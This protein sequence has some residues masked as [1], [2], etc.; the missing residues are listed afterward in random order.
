MSPNKRRGSNAESLDSS[1]ATIPV[2]RQRVSVACDTC[3][4]AREKCD[5]RR[6]HCGPCTNRN[7][8]CSYN[9]TSKKRGVQPG[10]L[11]TIELSLAWLFE[12][13]PECEASLYRLLTENDEARI[14]GS[15]NKAGRRLY[16]RWSKSR[17]REEIVRLIADDKSR[18]GASP[19]SEGGSDTDLETFPELPRP[20]VE[21]SPRYDTLGA[22][23]PRTSGNLVLPPNWRRLLEIYFTCTHCWFP[24][25][26]RD[27]M[28]STAR[29]YPA[30]GF[31]TSIIGSLPGPN[32]LLWACLAIG[33][34]QDAA[35]PRP[36]DY[37]HLSPAKIFTIARRLI[38]SEDGTFETSHIC[39]LLLH[40][41]VLLGQGKQMAA[42]LLVG[43]ACRLALNES[44]DVIGEV[45]KQATSLVF[46]ACFMLDTLI[47]VCL[48]QTGHITTAMHNQRST[49]ISSNPAA[50][51]IDEMPEPWSP[52]SGLGPPTSTTISEPSAQPI[53]QPLLTFHQLIKICEILSTDTRSKRDPSAEGTKV[54]VEDLARCLDS[55]F[56]FCN[57]LIYGGS[58]P[59]IPSAYLLQAVF[60]TAT[61]ELIPEPRPSLFS[62]LVETIQ[63]CLDTLGACAAPPLIVT[64][65]GAVQRH[66]HMGRMHETD[67]DKWRL[68]IDALT[69]V[70][71]QGSRTQEI[72]PVPCNNPS[73]D[74]VL[75]DISIGPLITQTFSA[76]A[77][78][79]ETSD[80]LGLTNARTTTLAH[81]GHTETPPQPLLPLR[82]HSN[83]KAHETSFITTPRST[84]SIP[85]EHSP[86]VEGQNPALNL[87]SSASQVQGLDYDAILDELGSVDC[88][89]GVEV[90]PQF[91][92]NL[93]FA[94][95]CD[96]GEM[97]YGNYGL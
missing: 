54:T 75:N 4:T 58:T 95:G 45:P 57:S 67:K 63:S 20:P 47:S 90:D 66:G 62:N 50:A 5:G 59:T 37:G 79:G 8:A 7:R 43:N 74:D 48:G 84:G 9:S 89:D 61:I 42:W 15:K 92:A 35:S 96:L 73:Q 26:D 81:I 10:Y 80:E 93:G 6:P 87:Y 1:V 21:P 88:T 36:S 40:S 19:S 31:D 18:R 44:S 51:N 24:I 82:Q 23:G 97:F 27:E 13:F 16:K 83:S 60:L 17:T 2:K 85:T 65:A 41:L 69:N 25:L 68:S 49:S 29:L 3:R 78:Y 34:F 33:A 30:A 70:W 12:Q 39:A 86:M 71:R 64:L 56:S 91:M 22:P 55:R 28:L 38:P 46:R 72:L 14:L 76:A 94:P 11:R 52:V 53:S 77:L 32:T